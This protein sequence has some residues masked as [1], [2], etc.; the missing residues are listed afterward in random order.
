MVLRTGSHC[1]KCKKLANGRVCDRVGKE[2]GRAGWLPWKLCM[3]LHVPS[4]E[5]CMSNLQKFI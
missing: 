2:K 5:T 1:N 3:L 4:K